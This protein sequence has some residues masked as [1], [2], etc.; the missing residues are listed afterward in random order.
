MRIDL[1]STDTPAPD[2]TFFIYDPEGG[3]FSYFK[4]AEAR[5]EA[6]ENIIQSYLDDGWDE[7]VEQVV[8]G[9][10]THTCQKIN[11]VPRPPEDQIDE[12]GCDR[13][14]EYWEP[15]WDYRCEYDL[16]PLSLAGD[17]AHV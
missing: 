7:T 17:E 14:G 13:D 12:K 6:K 11:L 4:S 10:V 15:N 2:R 1:S 3:G 8:A 16:L 9:E 5:D